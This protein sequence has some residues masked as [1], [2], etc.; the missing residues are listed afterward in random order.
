MNSSDSEV[1]QI[2]Q[3]LTGIIPEIDRTDIMTQEHTGTADIREMTLAETGISK[4]T[5]DI[6]IEMHTWEDHTDTEI[7]LP[8]I[9]RVNGKLAEE[10]QCLK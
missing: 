8:A 2:V 10:E 7:T 5:L 1:I 4:K 3:I 9:W 6:M